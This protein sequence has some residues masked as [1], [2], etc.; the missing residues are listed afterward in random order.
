MHFFP[1]GVPRKSPSHNLSEFAGSLVWKMTTTNDVVAES[2]TPSLLIQVHVL[3]LLCHP[4]QGRLEQL[5]KSVHLNNG[6]SPLDSYC[7]LHF[8]VFVYLC[9]P[10]QCFPHHCEGR[11]YSIV[12][13]HIIQRPT[14]KD[15]TD[16][17]RL[18]SRIYELLLKTTSGVNSSLIE[19]CQG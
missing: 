18:H 8:N 7:Y 13:N 10:Q 1:T 15:S 2:I 19:L 9:T 17:I 14:F 6:A 3:C 11:K 4:V 5:C 16:H 12:T